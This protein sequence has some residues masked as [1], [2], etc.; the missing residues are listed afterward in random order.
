MRRTVPHPIHN[1]QDPERFCALAAKLMW[2]VFRDVNQVESPNIM[3]FGPQK[4]AAASP[5][6]DD[7]MLMLV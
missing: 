5:H 1:A 4:D 3:P 6:Y 2:G 7:E